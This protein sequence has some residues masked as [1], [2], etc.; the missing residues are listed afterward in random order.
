VA[1]GDTSFR[2][3]STAT[4]EVGTL[5]STFNLMVESLERNQEARRKLISDLAH[6]MGTPLSVIQSNLEGML[7]GV[8]EPTSAK[9]SSLHQEAT[10]LARL[11]TDLR[12]LSQA[13]AGR[14]NLHLAPSDLGE[15]ISSIVT[16]NEPEAA[17]KGVSLSAELEPELPLAMMDAD[18]ISQVMVN[19]LSNAL[20]YTPDGGKINV[21]VG[22][23]EG[24]R[25]L[26][27][28]VADTGQGIPEVDL[29]YIFD[30][31]YRGP[32][33][34][35][36]RAGGSGIGLAVIKELVEAHSGRVWAVSTQGKG[37]TFYFT[38]PA[39]RAQVP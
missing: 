28:S 36:K 26:V 31:Y 18:R 37:S 29:P 11:V 6:E 33:P 17:R 25:G 12:T 15:L 21:T 9:I 19:L 10:L 27:V 3:P 8:V 32:E 16:A 1:K 14:L 2:V 23:E 35:E 34:K 38:V 4:D 24:G 20:R 22:R 30:R 7:D 39:N 5:A 13:E